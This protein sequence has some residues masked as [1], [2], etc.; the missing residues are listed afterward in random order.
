MRATPAQLFLMNLKSSI[1]PGTLYYMNKEDAY[2][3][4]K[5]LTGVDFGY[6]VAAWEEW[7]KANKKQIRNKK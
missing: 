3:G 2:E 1:K 5:K 7:I 4:L 6:D